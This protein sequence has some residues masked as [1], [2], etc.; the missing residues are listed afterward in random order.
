[1]WT[2]RPNLASQRSRPRA[3]GPRRCPFADTRESTMRL[4]LGALAHFFHTLLL[5]VGILARLV[6]V[7]QAHAHEEHDHADKPTGEA[8]VLVSPRVVA[9]SERYQFVG[10][11]EGEVLV[12]YLDRAEDN[13]P[14][15]T[16]TIEFSLNG[17]PFKAELQ[18]KAGTYEVTAPLLRKEASH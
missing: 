10:I 12:I 15:T 6:A 13:A 16:A 5:V 9:V 11:V 17:E 7:D 14:V 2:A 4:P 1:G 18:E 8:G 3:E